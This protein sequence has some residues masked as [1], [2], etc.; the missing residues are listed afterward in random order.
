MR[1][2]LLI[3]LSLSL[4]SCEDEWDGHI[5]YNAVGNTE[6]GK[7]LVE[8]TRLIATVFSD[9]T[10]SLEKDVD[11]TEMHYFSMKG[12][13]TRLFV[14][15]VNL[16]NSNIS[17]EITTPN[18]QKDFG[19][20]PMTEQAVYE[21]SENHQVLFG[22]NGDFFNTN[23]G[24]PNGILYKEGS[25][26]K[27]FTGGNSNFF[28]VLNSGIA[29]IG[30]ITKLEEVRDDIYEGLGGGVLLVKKG[31]LVSQSDETVNPRTCIGV[32][33]SGSKIIILE[34]DGRNY[35][36]SNG[37]TYEE[38]G[39]C[40]LALGAYD[41]LNLDGGGSSTFF[42]KNEHKAG[43]FVLRNWPCDNGGQERAVA[44]GIIVVGNY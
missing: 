39:Q 32:N 30:D 1:Y 25:M 41:A 23:T 5:V 3:F 40:M 29:V 18:N 10:Y 11:V 16:A 21:N 6:V 44:N 17:V 34:V 22:V 8:K 37:M 24:V 28:A 9:S 26:I 27:N 4:F 36:Y 15:E 7:A 19:F 2:L 14:A 42:I 35:H 20:Q 12:Y 38:L 31:V 13:S 33:E 43:Q